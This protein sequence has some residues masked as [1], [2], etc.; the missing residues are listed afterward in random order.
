MPNAFAD[1]S[2]I[3]IN[4]RQ[5][6]LRTAVCWTLVTHGRFMQKWEENNPKDKDGRSEAAE[7]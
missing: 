2:Q 5:V 1:R 7:K 6:L 4:S 3:N